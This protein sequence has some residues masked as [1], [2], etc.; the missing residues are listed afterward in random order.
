MIIDD[1]ARDRQVTKRT[2]L[3]AF[4][5][6]LV[7]ESSGMDDGQLLIET[8][9]YN[10]VLVDYLFPEYTGMDIIKKHLKPS[11]PPFIAFIM[12]TGEGDEELAA[13]AM[14]RGIHDYLV[15]DRISIASMSRAINNASKAA[16]FEQQN[17]YQQQALENFAGLVAHDL[18]TP[19]NSII[20]YLDMVI[21]S[22]AEK[23]SDN[24]LEYLETSRKSGR[25]MEGI[26]RDLLD[27]AKA[28]VSREVEKKISLKE[29]ID[30]ALSIMSNDI[31][32]N[33][34]TVQVGEM[35]EVT[36]KVCEFIQLFQNLIGNAIKYAD[37]THPEIL[38]TAEAQ[39]GDTIISVQDN[40]MGIP[41]DKRQEI[42]A[43]MSRLKHDAGGLGLGLATCQKIVA[44]HGGRI[45]CVAAEPSGTVFK[46]SLPN[47]R[48]ACELEGVL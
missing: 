22:D 45:W 6:A 44:S 19:L 41:K 13:N 25:Y 48:E 2:I 40:G 29:V 9:E 46:V 18:I 35:P 14:K 8:G 42:F 21:K 20:G 31:K 3:K 27:Y 39:E 34:V 38:I 47:T 15:K 43:P 12:I 11:A 30:G 36:V 7:E 1:D 26:I 4:P 24:A 5:D 33:N 23:L 10:C 28:G 17:Y 16:H 37:N 32:E